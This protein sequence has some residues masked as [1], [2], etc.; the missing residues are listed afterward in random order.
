MYRANSASKAVDFLAEDVPAAVEHAGYRLVDPVLVRAVGRARIG[1][2][3]ANC[4]RGV[5]CGRSGA[6]Y[7]ARFGVEPVQGTPE[8]FGH[9]YL[10]SPTGCRA[11][12]GIVGMIVAD[13]DLL[14]V[15]RKRLDHRLATLVG[16]D[17]G[18]SQRCQ[19][20]RRKAA[21]VECPAFGRRRHRRD[22]RIDGVVDIGEV[23]QLLA[24]PD[25]EGLA[26]QRE[27]DPDPEEGLAG[28][29]DPHARAVGVGQPQ[30]ARFQ[31]I[32]PVVEQMVELARQLVDAV[33]VGRHQGMFFIYRQIA[34]CAIDLAGA[35]EHDPGLGRHFPAGLQQVQLGF[36]ID[37]QVGEG[38]GHRVEMAGLADQIE[39]DVAITNEVG[40]NVPVPEVGQV[41]RNPVGNPIQIEPVAAVLGYQAVDNQDV[42]AQRDQAARQVRADETESAGDQ[43]PASLPLPVRAVLW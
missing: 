2:R 19:A 36:G 31:A 41:D 11:K 30:A 14:A 6:Q 9:V 20:D 35:G 22:E 37:R 29:L 13:V 12:G 43:H 1:L 5:H 10:R 4:R 8:A 26:F 21:D 39:D 42:G 33:H 15:H 18:L 28:V 38:I 25:L 7:C 27:A 16:G 3:Y 40:Q 17:Q 23:A 24:A 34:G 32:D